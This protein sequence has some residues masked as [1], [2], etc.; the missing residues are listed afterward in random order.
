MANQQDTAALTPESDRPSESYGEINETRF[1][2]A[3]EEVR[4][5]TDAALDRAFPGKD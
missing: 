1:K 2:A 4:A 5:G 3:P